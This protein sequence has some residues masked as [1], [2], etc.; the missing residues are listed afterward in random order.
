MDTF[1]S[2]KQLVDDYIDFAIELRK[3]H[4]NLRSLFGPR[5][6]EI[7]HP[8]HEAFDTAVE[9][10]CKDF[11]ASQPSQAELEAALDLLLLGAEEQEGKAPY[12]YLI[13]AQ[14]HATLLI[15]LL[16]DDRKAA[17]AS[18]Y[19]S[20]YPPRLQVPVQVQVYQALN[21]KASRR[22]FRLFGNP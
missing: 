21:P 13:A 3:K 15:P 22:K 5:T 16:D 17:L 14:R 20:Q 4:T 8:G 18:H 2:L 12:W 7:Y 19:A 11:A 10:W 9:N 6:E 1:N